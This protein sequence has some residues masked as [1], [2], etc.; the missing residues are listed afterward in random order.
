MLVVA[1][2]GALAACTPSRFATAPLQSVTTG[3]DARYTV[4]AQPSGDGGAEAW[5]CWK[6]QYLKLKIYKD[7]TDARHEA[8][9]AAIDAISRWCHSPT[10]VAV[11]GGTTDADLHCAEIT[12]TCQS[13]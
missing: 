12:L 13:D 2:C 10:V 4:R 8:T 7:P 1:V 6:P 11:H 9:A 3:D 5:A